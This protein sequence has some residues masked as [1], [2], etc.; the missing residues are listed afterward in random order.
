MHGERQILRDPEGLQTESEDAS[1]SKAELVT[2]SS[3]CCRYKLPHHIENMSIQYPRLAE[4]N[5][6]HSGH[7]WKRISHQTWTVRVVVSAWT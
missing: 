5:K 6:L 7:F 3:G 2:H 4:F 1:S